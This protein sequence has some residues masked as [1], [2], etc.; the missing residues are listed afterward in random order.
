M[1]KSEAGL[2]DI[3]LNK[4]VIAV[5][6][7]TQTRSLKTRFIYILPYSSPLKSKIATPSASPKEKPATSSGKKK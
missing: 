1:G 6:E 4:P 2:D 5:G 7:N 3:K